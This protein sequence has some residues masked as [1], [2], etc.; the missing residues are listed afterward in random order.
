MKNKADILF[1][2]NIKK[3]IESGYTD[4]EGPRPK[5]ED[6]TPAESKFIGPVFETY[7]IS[8]GEFPLITLRKIP[9]KMAIKEILWIYQ[10][11]SNSLKLLKEKYNIS[12]WDFWE[13]KKYPETIGLRYGYSIKKFDQVNALIKNLKESPYSRRHIISMWDIESFQES[14]GLIPCAFQTMWTVRDGFLDMTLIQRSSDSGTALHINQIQYVAL[15]MMIAQECSLKVGRFSHLIQNYHIY[16]RHLEILET[17]LD[18]PSL[19]SS[20]TLRLKEGKGFYDITIEDFFVD[21]Y[22]IEPS[23]F[24]FELAI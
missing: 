15:M 8:K 12:W 13:S 10:D 18:K 2:E 4:T 23:K 5:W 16:N 7:D 20:P 22:D 19:E 6:G 21:D 14:D 17:F 11:Q 1:K 24:K 3:I 9:W